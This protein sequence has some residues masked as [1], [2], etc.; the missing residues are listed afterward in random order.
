MIIDI[1]THIF[2]NQL[3]KKTIPLLSKSAKICPTTDGTL[4]SLQN[5]SSRAGISINVIQNIVTN[6]KQTINVNNFAISLLNEH[7][8]IPFGSIHP[9]FEGWKYELKRLKDAGIKG[10]K[11][12]PDYQNFFI[13]DSR[14]Y[15]LY[16]T[17]QEMEFLLLVH[18]GLDLGLQEPTHCL[19]DGLLKVITDF[20]GL[21]LIAAHIGGHLK[22]NEVYEKLIGTN[23]YFDTSFSARCIE[24]NLLLK[25]IRDH[26]ADKFLFGTDSPWS[27]AKKDI[28]YFKRLPIS[29]KEREQIF[30]GTAQ[31]LLNI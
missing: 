21:P 19:P 23:I 24:E 1:H 22:W 28:A 15:P 27:D 26:G 10:I 29:S 31:Q 20:P 8:I 11:I 6:P 2:P 4:D 9:D 16:E 3:A 17:I 5:I 14:L 7:G 12:H 25:M 13:E 18:A 30:S